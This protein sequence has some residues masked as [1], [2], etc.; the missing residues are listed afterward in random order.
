VD[1]GARGI[2]APVWV[3][4]EPTLLD[5]ILTNLIDNSFRYGVPGTRNPAITVAVERRGDEVLLSVQDNG[6]GVPREQLL[7]LAER[8]SQGEAGQLL[9]QGVGLGLALVAQYARLMNARMRLDTGDEGRG[10]LCE[11]AFPAVNEPS[12]ER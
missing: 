3:A 10:W 4:A 1:L 5:G 9:G 11:I 7:A 6:P 2:D 12:S 8:G